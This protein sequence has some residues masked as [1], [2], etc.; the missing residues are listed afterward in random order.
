MARPP[1][2]YRTIASVATT[3]S[4]DL[5]ACLALLVALD[6]SGSDHLKYSKIE[7][8]RALERLRGRVRIV[9]QQNR[10]EC[11]SGDLGRAGPQLLGLIDSILRTVPFDGRKRSFHPKVL[12]ARQQSRGR[13]DRY[14]LGVGS[15]NLTASS[16]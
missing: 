11:H 13:P 8:L 16:A 7:A 15:R 12:I 9:A 1:D 6:G 5:V 3:Y 14:I 10:V 2:G 4:A